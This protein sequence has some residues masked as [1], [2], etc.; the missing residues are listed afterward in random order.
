MHFILG[1]MLADRKDSEIKEAMQPLP[2]KNTANTIKHNIA[3]NILFRT[4][5]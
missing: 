1:G 3:G 5:Y 4:L 2:T